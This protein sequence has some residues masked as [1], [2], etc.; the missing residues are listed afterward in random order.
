MDIINISISYYNNGLLKYYLGDYDGAIA[1][2]NK[3]IKLNPNYEEAYYIRG[4]SKKRLGDIDGYVN[5][6][7][8][9]EKLKNK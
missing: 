1:D 6:F 2:L 4:K 5:D 8:M 7:E 9:Y 3:S